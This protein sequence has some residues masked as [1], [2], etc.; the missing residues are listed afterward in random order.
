MEKKENKNVLMICYYFPPCSTVGALRSTKFVK[1]LKDFGWKAHVI[2]GYH[3]SKEVANEFDC[4]IN[5]VPRIDLTEIATIL[6]SRLKKLIKY[7]RKSK[8]QVTESNEAIQTRRIEPNPPK[9]S[10][11]HPARFF[12]QWCIPD[13]QFLWVLFALPSALWIS[14]KCNV[15]YTSAF[16]VSMHICGLILKK[17]TGK[18]WIADYRDEWSLNINLTYPT[19]IHKAISSYL[20]AKCVKNADYVINVTE[21]RTEL[22]KNHFINEN[23]NKF[24]TI[25]NGYDDLEQ[26][27]QMRP[28]EGKTVMTSIGSLYGGR[29]PVLFMQAV[30]E[31]LQEGKLSREKIKINLIGGI[32]PHL[33]NQVKQLDLEDV[34]SMAP[35]IPQS[36]ALAAV[37][38]SHIALLFGSEM[39]RVAMTTKV[40]EYAGLGKTIL[41]L[42][43]EGQL[44]GFVKKVGG[45]AVD[46]LD[47]KTIEEGILAAI[48][49]CD[50][51]IFEDDN[52]REYVELFNRK[53]LTKQLSILF[54]NCF[55]V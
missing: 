20:D 47:K 51:S 43:P 29:N 26:F 45:T 7:F 54:D 4:K 25:H 40:Y 21:A 33:Q 37:A 9:K 39:E 17:L 28:T 14:R 1:Y 11:W 55:S 53:L 13:A 16:P 41:A 15:I 46:Y 10:R 12:R 30:S 42:V 22:F 8:Q 19:K 6:S 48:A 49:S 35:R 52:I 31:L 5:W 18:P 32:Y 2:T 24:V 34:I 27:K 3:T 23:P 50:E 38:S 36:D 44:S